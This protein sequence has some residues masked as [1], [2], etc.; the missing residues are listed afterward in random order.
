M[1]LREDLCQKQDSLTFSY[2]ASYSAV[3]NVLFQEDWIN[4]LK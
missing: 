4:R 3:K 1:S 2:I